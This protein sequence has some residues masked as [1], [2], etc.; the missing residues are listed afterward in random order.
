M[1]ASKLTTISTIAVLVGGTSLA[2]G[3][4]LQNGASTEAP[5]S[6]SQ[7][8]ARGSETRDTDA[9]AAEQGSKFQGSRQLQ[10]GQAMTTQRGQAITGAHGQ[11]TNGESGRTME[12][13]GLSEQQRRPHIGY[14]E[15]RD[16]GRPHRGYREYSEVGRPH[17][18]YREQSEFSEYARP[19]RGY[20]ERGR[21]SEFGPGAGYRERSEYGKY[22]GQPGG[23]RSKY[24]R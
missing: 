1:R 13:T 2:L 16:F 8:N 15:Y 24:G 6:M 21:Y 11:A 4:S 18:G 23:Q 3:H 5:A 12:T 19:H 20:R 22:R 9:Q 14:R 10:R 17:R 7:S